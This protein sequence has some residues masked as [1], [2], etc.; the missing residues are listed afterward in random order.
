MG[1]FICTYDF[2][3][4]TVRYARTHAPLTVADLKG[5]HGNKDKANKLITRCGG[6]PLKHRLGKGI[7]PLAESRLLADFLIELSDT[8]DVPA[9][10]YI[11]GTGWMGVE[12][13]ALLT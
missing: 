4:Q 10:V 9:F 8:F 5:Q 3:S 13:G 11:P 12:D 1:C 6:R 7:A 2:A